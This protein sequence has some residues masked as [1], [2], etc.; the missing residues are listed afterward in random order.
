MTEDMKLPWNE[1]WAFLDSYCNL[2]TPNG[3]EMLEIYLEQKKF[4]EILEC[5]LKSARVFISD[6]RNNNDD[7]IE[8]NINKSK[9]VILQKLSQFISKANHLKDILELK[10]NQLSH[11]YEQFAKLVL[12]N[13]PEILNKLDLCDRQDQINATNECLNQTDFIIYN[14]LAQYMTVIIELCKLDKSSKCYFNLYKKSRELL[15][16]I[17]CEKA[18][19]HFYL[20]PT[21]K[22]HATKKATRHPVL[23]NATNLTTFRK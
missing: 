2:K 15:N 3:L 4:Q 6:F 17:N 11:R 10:D 8:N 7:Q 9:E 22:K 1:H 13:K 12:D 18:F 16:L 23:A 20:S 5:Q 19:Y 21:F 14:S